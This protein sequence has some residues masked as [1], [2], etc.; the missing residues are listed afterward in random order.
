VVRH[1]LADHGAPRLAV[2]AGAALMFALLAKEYFEPYPYYGPKKIAAVVFCAALMAT[3]A[4]WEVLSGKRTASDAC[5]FWA[6]AALRLSRWDDHPNAKGH[7]L[8][9]DV[10]FRK[11][12]ELRKAGTFASPHRESRREN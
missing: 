3:G 8:I 11:L 5:G 12:S 10:I 6:V 2:V 7:K 1:F 9:A 4:L